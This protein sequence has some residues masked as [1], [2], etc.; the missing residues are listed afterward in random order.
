[1]TTGRKVGDRV[2]V[3]GAS[4]GALLAAKELAESFDDVV[5]VDRD[6]V[7]DNPTYRRGFRTVGTRTGL[8]RRA[9]RSSNG[10]SPA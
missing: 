3:L 8:S 7:V 5:L 6:E 10:S 2:V 9:S 1:M 4:L